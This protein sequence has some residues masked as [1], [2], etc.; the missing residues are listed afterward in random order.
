MPEIDRW[1]ASEE[2][3][4]PFSHCTR[5]DLPLVEIATPWLVN[6]EYHRGECVFEYAL[7]QPCRDAVTAD[8]S[9]ESKRTVRDF[10]ER[11]IDWNER[12]AQFMM[13][14][15]LARRFDSC[16]ACGCESERLEGFGISAAFDGGG[17]LTEGPLP[18]LICSDCIGKATRNL[19]KATREAWQ[20][21]LEE[22]FD[23][24]P[25]K[26]EPLPGGGMSGLI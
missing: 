10:L 11:A 17:H 23:G 21:F 24:P 2:A 12:L 18:L 16:I 4:A 25:G 1:L 19:S 13:L 5:C 3:G 9:E 8:F 22:N 20:R 7:C 15:D 6:K 26:G 14:P